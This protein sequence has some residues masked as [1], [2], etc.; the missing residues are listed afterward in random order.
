MRV[1]LPAR[2]EPMFWGDADRR[3]GVVKEVRRR[4]DVLMQDSGAESYQKDLICQRAIFISIQLETMEVEAAQSGKFDPGCYTQMVNTLL[5]LLKALG[6][7]RQTKKT[8]D[9]KAYVKGRRA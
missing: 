9:L 2:F 7:E 1:D 3:S 8:V 6:L 5:G 4:Y